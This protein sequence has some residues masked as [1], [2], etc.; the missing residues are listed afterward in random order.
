MGVAPGPGRYEHVGTR[1]DILRVGPDRCSRACSGA[2]GEPL[3]RVTVVARDGASRDRP[4]PVVVQVV[5]VLGEVNV[6]T[7][8]ILADA[9]ADALTRAF[10][11]EGRRVVVDATEM[12]FC[13]VRGLRLLISAERFAAEFGVV[14]AYTGF[15]R[16]LVRLSRRLEPDGVGPEVYRDRP[17]AIIAVGLG[18]PW[19]DVPGPCS[20][21]GSGQ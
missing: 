14:Y 16:R 21:P 4:S 2:A 7:V 8:R 18:P 3:L 12:T 19:P 10:T 5:R 11:C 1:R 20:S 13:G 6:A 9:M 15:P 17:T